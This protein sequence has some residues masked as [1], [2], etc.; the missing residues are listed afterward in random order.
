MLL[1]VYCISIKIVYQINYPH[2]IYSKYATTA[3]VLSVPKDR[4]FI[5]LLGRMIIDLP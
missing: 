2:I 1:G 5:S 3:V 4:K